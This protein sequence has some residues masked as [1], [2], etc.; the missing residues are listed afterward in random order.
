MHVSN[1]VRYVAAIYYYLSIMPTCY[2]SQC[3]QTDLVHHIS[4]PLGDKSL[5]PALPPL[6]GRHWKNL[7]DW[8]G[9]LNPNSFL[10]TQVSVIQISFRTI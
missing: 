2:L 9:I 6:S 1:T 3:K 4:D 10:L 8:E 5:L 7:E